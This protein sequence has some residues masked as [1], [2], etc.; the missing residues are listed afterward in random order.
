ME[1]I[2]SILA[3]MVERI[4][5]I[6]RKPGEHPTDAILRQGFQAEFVWNH[7]KALATDSADAN[8]I[9][10]LAAW[11]F[12]TGVKNHDALVYLMAEFARLRPRNPF[13]Y[14]APGSAARD[15]V[16]ER[17]HGERSAVEG[18]KF[19]AQDRELMEGLGGRHDG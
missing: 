6:S 15:G 4:G 16:L 3:P 10:R 1:D 12:A 9:M 2:K 5:A 8:R 13:A 18:Q 14:F 7:A 11:L 19:K 17:F